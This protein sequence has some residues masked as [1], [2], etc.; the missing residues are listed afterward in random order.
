MPNRALG[1]EQI[2]SQKQSL[3]LS[4]TT[5]QNE[6]L[7]CKVLFLEERLRSLNLASFSR[8]EPS[9]CQPRWPV[10]ESSMGQPHR[11]LD[12]STWNWNVIQG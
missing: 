5:I 10:K 2:S 9:G 8:L 4:T 3:D 11:L 6:V 7:N 12:Y 1:D